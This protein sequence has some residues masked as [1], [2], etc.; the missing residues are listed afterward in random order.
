[1]KKIHSI[2]QKYAYKE[3]RNKLYVCEEC[4]HTSGTQDELLQHLHSLHPDSHLLKGKA[5]RRTGGGGGREGGPFGESTPG[6]PQGAE[7]DDT[8]GSIEQ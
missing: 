2:T 1:M 7:S 8:N 4:G 6:S 5:V 3:R